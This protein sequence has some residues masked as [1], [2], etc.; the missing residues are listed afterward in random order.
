M[1]LNFNTIKNFFRYDIRW[2]LIKIGH[3]LGIKLYPDY[4]FNSGVKSLYSKILFN[5]IFSE[6]SKKRKKELLDEL[7]LILS[8]NNKKI[9][10]LISSP[11]SGGNYVRHL[12]SSHFEIFYKIGNG[13]PKFNNM[14]NKFM[15]SA[16]PILSGD[17]FNFIELER[18]KLNFKFFSKEDFYKKKIILSRFPYPSSNITLHP[19]LYKKDIIKPLILFRDPLDWI[20]SRYAKKEGKNFIDTNLIDNELFYYQ[21]SDYTKY[22]SF[23]LD[24]TNDKKKDEYLLINFETLITDEKKSFLNILKFFNYEILSENIIDKILEVNS[25]EF[26]IK[27]LGV[28]FLGTRFTNQERR[29]K[30][31]LKIKEHSLKDARFKKLI[32][33]A[34]KLKMNINIS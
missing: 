25:K 22:V 1:K 23:W 29:N 28:K 18:N 33:L 34:N 4:L 31:K 26:A 11:S 24:Y 8:N 2:K 16:T 13:I 32:D 3:H 30:I 9:N 10:F 17:I 7:Q 27:D 12:L 19:N 5:L 6:K 20:T 15:F 21:I 14:T